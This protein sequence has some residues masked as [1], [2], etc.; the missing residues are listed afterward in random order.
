MVPRC[1]PEAL[2]RWLFQQLITAVDY[3]HRVGV[4]NRDI[5]LENLLI[6]DP[7]QSYPVILLCDFGFAKHQFKDSQCKTAVGTPCYVAPEVMCAQMTNL[8]YDGSKA[9]MWS[10]GICLYFMLYGIRREPVLKRK[11]NNGIGRPGEVELEFPKEREWVDGPLEDISNDCKDF[12]NRILQNDAR[13]RIKTE[14]VWDHPWFQK[15]LPPSARSY[16]AELTKD[17][18]SLS[19]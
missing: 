14:D 4:N 8:K 15:D 2:A 17:L 3:C 19:R 10:S 18:P 13:L 16:N 7:N 5:K 6:D 1:L 12:L 9:D 11:S